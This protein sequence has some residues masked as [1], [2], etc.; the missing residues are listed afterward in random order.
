MNFSQA[1]EQRVA[2][3]R[4]VASGRGLG[5][6]TIS[7]YTAN[8]VTQAEAKAGLMGAAMHMLKSGD[9]FYW[10]TT[11]CDLVIST[12]PAMPEMT[13]H[14]EDLI[15]PFG[16][17]WFSH[18]LPLTTPGWVGRD[19][20]ML[21]YAWGEAF[22]QG[23]LLMPFIPTPERV[24]GGPSQLLMWRYGDTFEQLEANVKDLAQRNPGE[25]SPELAALRRCEQMKYIAACTVFMNQRI[26]VAK[27]ERSP[28]A[29]RRRLER[30]GVDDAL[31]R[32]VQLRRSHP[33]TT[34][35]PEHDAVEWSCQWVV[36]GHW[37]QQACGENHAERRPVFVLPHIKGPSDKP[38]KAPAD[39]V[40][41]VTR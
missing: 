26:L 18:P 31:I 24:S 19:V 30:E 6:M 22:G 34:A 13:L 36:S 40:F 10:D 9:P 3:Y 11:T 23:V 5:G 7:A 39:R 25:D 35:G 20:P 2:L 4:Y 33:D 38:L 27:Q 41:A 29:T 1:I 21:G 28:R 15:V 8:G 14:P 16:F 17:C 12:A 32:V 37:R